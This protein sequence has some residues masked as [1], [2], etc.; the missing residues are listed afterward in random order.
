MVTARIEEAAGI[1]INFRGSLA[2]HP[3]CNRYGL[4]F[5]VNGHLHDALDDTG[6]VARMQAATVHLVFDRSNPRKV[7]KDFASWLSLHPRHW[8][9]V[10]RWSAKQAWRMKDDL[11]AAR[12]RV[13]TLSFLVHGFMDACA[14][15]RER[16]EA[17]VFKT[18][19]RDGPVSM[20]L[21]NAK[22]D[23][24]I[25]Q[26]IP[27]LTLAGRRFWQPLSGTLSPQPVAEQQP[28]PRQ[29]GRKR[30]KGRTRKWLLEQCRD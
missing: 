29:C 17:C 1:S 23:N 19:T 21:H 28:D 10:L 3:Q 16:I 14:L 18:M 8:S 25:L 9:A 24:F 4:C 12:G 22:R 15:E 6:F 30:A 20:C 7:I 11:F 13:D 27:V 2:G 5:A 26:P